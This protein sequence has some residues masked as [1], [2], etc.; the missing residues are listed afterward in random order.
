MSSNKPQPSLTK[1]EKELVND[2]VKEAELKKGRKVTKHNKYTPKERAAIGKYAAE[3]GSS[4]ACKHF[5]KELGR[6]I[7]ESTARKLRDEYL[8]QLKVQVD[9]QGPSCCPTPPDV[10]VLPT[11]K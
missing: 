8:I 1:V 9:A 6:R 7:P 5:T 2:F 10:Q 3:N 4:K 11:K